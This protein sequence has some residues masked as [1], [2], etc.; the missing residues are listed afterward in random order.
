MWCW[1][2]RSGMAMG[3]SDHPNMSG[4]CSRGPFRSLLSIQQNSQQAP[5]PLRY[6]SRHTLNKHMYSYPAVNTKAAIFQPRQKI[7]AQT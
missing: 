5:A 7:F 3:D 2:P 1:G 6:T 4:G